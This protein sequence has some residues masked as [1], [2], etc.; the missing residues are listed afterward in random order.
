MTPRPPFFITLQASAAALALATTSMAHAD[1]GKLLLTGGVSTIAGSAGGGLTPWA[2]IG[3]NATEGEVGFS[4]YVT[5]A[6]TQDYSLSGYG[7]AVGV[8]DRVELSLARQDFDASPA[9]ALNGIAPFGVTPGQH[10]QMDVV[11]VKLKVAGDAVLNSDSWMPQIAVGLE[12]KRVRPGSIGSVLDFLGTHTSGTDVY[13]SATKLLLAQSLLVNG[14]LRS[15]N[16]NQ[17]GLLGFGAATPGKN[18]RSLQPEFSVAYLIQKNLAVGA[19]VRFKPNNLQAL[20]AAAGLGGALREDD[21]KD[22]FIAW[23]PSKNL[24]LT[25]AYVDLGRIVP[26]IT[27]HRRQT[28]YYLSAQV[29]F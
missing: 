13:V 12:H 15:T 16:A 24:S 25:L 20:G 19:E 10:I 28:G 5:R 21:W 17:N 6:A 26:G 18:R 3:S 23:A 11:G 27:H 2:V 7:V 9:V 4:G 14:T 8:H 22:I 1:T 29:A